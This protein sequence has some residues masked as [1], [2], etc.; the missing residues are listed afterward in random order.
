MTV[1]VGSE[2]LTRKKRIDTKLSSLEPA[3]RIVPYREGMDL[4]RLT[5]HAVEEFPT[6][7]GPAGYALFVDGKMMGIVEAKKVTVN[8]QNVM[9]QAKRYAAGAFQ[10]IG[11]WGGL[12][13]PFLYATNGAQGQLFRKRKAAHTADLWLGIIAGPLSSWISWGQGCYK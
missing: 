8:P 12:R 3:W 11:N 2:W 10:G 1:H 6:V 13:V 5:C 9:E 7:N 4:S